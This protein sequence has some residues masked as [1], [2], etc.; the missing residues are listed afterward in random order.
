MENIRL[1]L[2]GG[3][4]GKELFQTI[5]YKNRPVR[6]QGLFIVHSYPLTGQVGGII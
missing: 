4:P 5:A 1:A 6:C 2:E 3:D